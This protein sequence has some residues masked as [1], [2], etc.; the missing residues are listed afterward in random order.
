MVMETMQNLAKMYEKLPKK[1]GN[2]E[3]KNNFCS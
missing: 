2:F 1:L 3:N